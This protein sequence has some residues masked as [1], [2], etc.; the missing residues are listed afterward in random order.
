MNPSNIQPGIPLSHVP[1]VGLAAGQV[2]E[3]VGGL[4][5]GQ[6]LSVQLESEGFGTIVGN[7]QHLETSSL[8]KPTTAFYF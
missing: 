6:P 2:E 3:M 1:Q 7:V 5:N 8:V 4:E